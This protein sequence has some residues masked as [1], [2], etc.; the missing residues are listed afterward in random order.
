MKKSI[1]FHRGIGFRFTLSI[2]LA[3][4]VLYVAIV[5]LIIVRFRNNSVENAR[6]LTE[7]LAREYANM[8]TADLNEDM[9]LT[10]AMAAAFKSNWEQ[11][12]ADNKH[13][14][15][16]FLSNIADQSPDVMA[17]WIS[18]ELSSFIDGYMHDYGRIRHTLVTLPG[19]EAFLSEMVNLDGDDP[20]SD[21]FYLK[22]SKITE[23][24]EPYFDS[25]G[26]D[27]TV[28]LMS[29]VCVPVLDNE[30]KFIGLAGFDF[31][32]NR[33]MP[34][35]EQI[36][37]YNGTQAMVVSNKGVVVAHP[38]RKQ[39]M[40]NIDDIW[41]VNHDIVTSINGQKELSFIEKLNGDS[42]FVSMAPIVLSNSDTP[43]SLVLVVPQKSVL[44]N[45]N[46]T[47][48]M[49]VVF[50]FLGL[51]LLGIIIIYLSK[52][53]IVPIKKCIDFARRVGSGNLSESLEIKRRDEIGLLSRSLNRMTNELRNIVKLMANETG[54]L[55]ASTELLA[56]T[57]QKL[58]QSANEQLHSGEMA[59]K[60]VHDLTSFIENSKEKTSNV[61]ALSKKATTVLKESTD[62]FNHSVE[63]MD[64]VSQKV[65][66]IN[67]IAFQTNILALNA[68][69]EAARAGDAGRGFSVVAG[70]VRK[71]AE[72]SKEVAAQITELAINTRENSIDAGKSL[73]ETYI[74]T[75]HYTE[76]VSELNRYSEIQ[77]ESIEKIRD[78]MDGFK[79]LSTTSTEQAYNINEI[80]SELK[81]QTEKLNELSAKFKL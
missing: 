81:K 67:D 19:Q 9:N 69:V 13:F 74:Q 66:F 62:K 14:Y 6:F 43:W 65:D 27:T 55:N 48:Y 68:A 38:E 22:T 29:S 58:T 12:N 3:S 35:V 4:A 16:S 41:S 36:V 23:F 2:L 11:G 75:N 71:L 54:S 24:S 70:E 1:K 20:E 8:A 47:V 45:V 37:P 7:S 64:L 61:S 79:I 28:Y 5:S 49:A 30:K 59:N 53:L 44:E 52:S 33:L 21:Y 34:F 57:A 17:V 80:A 31:S 10:R 32:L 15:E 39:I 78:T 77:I 73:N 42:Y 56:G 25:Y 26:T 76:I 63:Q 60:S 72:R 40:K 18:M 51:L 46:R 50:C